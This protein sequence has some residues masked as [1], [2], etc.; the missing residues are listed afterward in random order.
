[1]GALLV[2]GLADVLSSGRPDNEIESF[3][4]FT[5]VMQILS[6]FRP[7]IGSVAM[8]MKQQLTAMDR[9]RIPSCNPVLGVLAKE[10]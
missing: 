5:I 6:C 10:G 4:L 2:A 1:M 8:Q 7:A 9:V 3:N